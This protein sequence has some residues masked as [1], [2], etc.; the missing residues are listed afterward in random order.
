MPRTYGGGGGSL[1]M[2]GMPP[3]LV[4]PRASLSY[5]PFNFVLSQIVL[6]LSSCEGG[7]GRNAPPPRKKSCYYSA[8]P[9]ATM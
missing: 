4:P 1:G 8:T 2:G 5:M 9:V 6:R 7:T 3:T